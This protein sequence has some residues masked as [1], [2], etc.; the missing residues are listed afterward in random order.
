CWIKALVLRLATLCF[1]IAATGSSICP[2]QSV[3]FDSI[4]EGNTYDTTIVGELNKPA[5]DGIYSAVIL[6]HGCSGIT[7]A[8]RQGLED[9]SKYLVSRGF[10][11]LI[12]D[13]FGPRNKE[14]GIVCLQESEQRAAL[15]YRQFDAYHALQFLQKQSSID[16][17]NIFLMGQSHGGSVALSSA[18]GPYTKAF[19]NSPGFQG[20]VAYYPWCGAV[21]S[22]PRKLVTPVLIFGA[23]K[24]DWLNPI[25][26]V[27]AKKLV[28]GASFEV[29]IYDNLHHGFD[30]PIPEQLYAGHIVGGDIPATK[31]SQKR[32]V[33]WFSIHQ[34]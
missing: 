10:A 7:S 3:S 1:V 32:M 17:K 30:L 4:V 24:D 9:H 14:D 12:I 20:I 5:G 31:D 2:A 21:P 13:S 22:W 15:Y 8:V 26:C 18:A 11:T 23:G 33:D 6:M 27:K 19:P 29:Y 28:G 16:P 34:Q 25:D